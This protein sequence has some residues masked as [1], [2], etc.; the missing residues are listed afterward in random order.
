[1]TI[2]HNF[3]D[4]ART[5][6]EAAGWS[7]DR[8]IDSAGAE[9]TLAQEGQVSVP[10]VRAFLRRYGQLRLEFASPRVPHYVKGGGFR[11]T[12]AMDT[13]R[14]MTRPATKEVWKERVREYLAG[15]LGAF[16]S[17]SAAVV[18]SAARADSRVAAMISATAKCADSS[19]P[20][21]Q[22]VYRPV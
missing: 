3:S 14:G 2:S 17:S 10:V 18:Q 21:A 12:G 19:A 11:R 6:L 5:A 22:P 20:W 15:A 4:A 13:L 8:D 7:P 9:T 16:F 1:M